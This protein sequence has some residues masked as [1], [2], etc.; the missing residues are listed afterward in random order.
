MTSPSP[1]LFDMYY[2]IY[3]RGTNGENIFIQERNYEYFLKLYEKHISP[4]ADTF[5]YCMLR[6][7]FHIAV[8]IK[9]EEEIIE[10]LRVSSTHQNQVKQGKSASQ[11]ESWSEKPLGSIALDYASQRFS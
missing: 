11:D 1:L 2:H 5:A 4:I 3:N 8:R 6:N 10:T 9:S 7:H